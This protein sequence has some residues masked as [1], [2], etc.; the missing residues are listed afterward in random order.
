MGAIGCEIMA[1]ETYI[2]L[3][4]GLWPLIVGICFVGIGSGMSILPFIPEMM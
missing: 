4:E 3:P 1:P 2:G